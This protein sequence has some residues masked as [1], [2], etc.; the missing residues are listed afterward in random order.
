MSKALFVNFATVAGASFLFTLIISNIVL[1]ILKGRKLGQPIREEGPKEH[2]SKAGT[3]TMGGI[4]FIISIL[5]AIVSMSIVYI[6]VDRQSELIPLAITL[7]FALANGLIGFVDDYCKLLKKQN[8]GLTPRAKLILQT[9]AAGLYVLALRLFADLS[10]AL[11]IPFTDV[12]IELSWFYY[13]LAIFLI[14]GVV[15]S[16][17]LT[18]GIDGLATCVTLVVM[19]FFS[20]AAM[21]SD[22]AALILLA[23]ATVGG[24][25]GFLIFNF[26]PAK[27]FM[28]DTGSLFLGAAA[29]GAAFLVNQPLIILIVG[30]I[31]IFEAASVVIQVLVFKATKKRAQ[32]PKRVFRM[33][34]VHHHFELGGWSENKIVLIF[35]LV[36]LALAL[37]A[38]F[39]L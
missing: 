33:T 9:V 14:V 12:S 23:S 25:F 39:G 30:G 18:D 5:L 22:N 20:I 15:N 31:Y 32:G 7:V 11:P 4:S 29:V 8:E 16:V 34:P 1:P 19:V 35:S 26:H 36:T 27:V 24:L 38:W 3:P 17:N 6:V 10:T 28:G 37:I 13:V 21:V 2:Q